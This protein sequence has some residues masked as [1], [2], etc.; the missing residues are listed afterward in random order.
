MRPSFLSDL[1]SCPSTYSA[2]SLVALDVSPMWLRPQVAV[3]LFSLPRYEVDRLIK[4]K[5]VRVAWRPNQAGKRHPLIYAP[6]LSALLEEW[7][8]LPPPN[9]L[10][11]AK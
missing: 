9:N 2:A 7:G 6:S 11:E 10:K 4:E 8:K 3:K 1:P 5:L